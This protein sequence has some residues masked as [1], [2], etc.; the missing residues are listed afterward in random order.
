[1]SPDT[2]VRTGAKR[3]ARK[4]AASPALRFLA[5]AGYVANGI[6]H[7]LVGVIV[8]VIAFGGDGE[9][10]QAGAFKAVAA[11]P[12]G[13]AALWALAISLWALGAWHAAAGL[14]AYD[15]RGDATGSAKKWG[16][17]LAEWGQ[18]V[19]FLALGTLA[20]A[21]AIG[22]RPDTEQVAEGA[23]RGILSIP[24]GPFVLAAVGL[25]IGVGGVVFVVMG[26]RQSFEK[27]VDVPDG[28]LGAWIRALGV[29]GFVAKGL[30]LLVLGVILVVAAVSI[31][32]DAAGS[33]DGAV[34]AILALPLGPVLAG[35]V[36]AGFIAYGV[37]C[38]FRARYAHL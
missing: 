30:A 13:F 34:R 25:G 1:M 38:G 23:S 14:L 7:A 2:T 20:A 15:P 16:R 24:G 8:L 33:L 19:V 17:R 36:G 9:G 21:V 28:A 26:V 10:D 4:A 27:P 5:R 29:A 11:A 6:V 37:F 3:A 31:D 18:A 35:V 12:A 32:P 22:A